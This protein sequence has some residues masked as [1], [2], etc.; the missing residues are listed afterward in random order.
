MVKNEFNPGNYSWELFCELWKNTRELIKNQSEREN[1]V[2]LLRLRFL[3]KWGLNIR[4]I[5]VSLFDIW[6]TNFTLNYLLMFMKICN[7]FICISNKSDEHCFLNESG[8]W[9]V[10]PYY[11]RNTVL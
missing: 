8:Y 11:E 6:G 5:R 2:F 1:K 4:E 3:R 7:I 9:T 10:S